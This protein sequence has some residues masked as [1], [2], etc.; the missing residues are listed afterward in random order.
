MRKS[1]IGM[2]INKGFTLIEILVVIVIIGIT[3][4]FAVIAFGDFGEGRRILFAADQLVNTLRLTQQKAIL[5]TSTYGLHIDSNSYQI[6]KFN[7]LSTWSPVSDKGIFNLKYFPKNTFIT[8]HTSN[9]PK[10]NVPSI[11]INAS[12][13]MTPFTLSIGPSKEKM[14]ARIVGNHNGNLTIKAL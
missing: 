2:S 7:N 4:G 8:L 5:E 3:V 10:N 12:G 11:I 6:L 1:V 13:N 9:Q 14:L